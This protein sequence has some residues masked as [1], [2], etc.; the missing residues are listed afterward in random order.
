MLQLGEVQRILLKIKLLQN[1]FLI[2]GIPKE[3]VITKL[4]DYSANIMWY[5]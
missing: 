4:T 3:I 5:Y 2:K 1:I